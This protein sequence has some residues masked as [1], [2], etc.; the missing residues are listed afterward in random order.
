MN[1]IGGILT[2][3]TFGLLLLYGIILSKRLMNKSDI[4]WNQNIYKTQD[5]NFT[6]LEANLTD[7]DDIMVEVLLTVADKAVTAK[8]IKNM[9]VFEMYH[10]T[11]TLINST[12]NENKIIKTPIDPVEWSDDINN[13]ITA[14]EGKS[15]SMCYSFS[16]LSLTIGESDTLD[17]KQI[18]FEFNTC[19]LNFVGNWELSPEAIKYLSSSTILVQVRGKYINLNDFENPIQPY[20]EILV[21]KILSSKI[22]YTNIVDIDKQE[23][24]FEDTIW[25]YLFPPNPIYF[26]KISDRNTILHRDLLVFDMNKSVSPPF[27]FYFSLGNNVHQYRWVLYFIVRKYLIDI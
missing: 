7:F 19:K 15:I 21:E 5:L 3:L 27:Q 26:Y 17:R 4:Q 18:V 16:N 12:T 9:G 25:F 6:Y 22:V 1:Y 8:E 13:R 2:I 14:S 11:A 24:T 20:N 10:E 23:A